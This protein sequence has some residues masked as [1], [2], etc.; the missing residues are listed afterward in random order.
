LTADD[1]QKANNY[2]LKKPLQGL[3]EYAGLIANTIGSKYDELGAV[4]VPSHVYDNL[5]NLLEYV[6]LRQP[7][8]RSRNL[9]FL[10]LRTL[11]SIKSFA[12]ECGSRK[13][14]A[15]M[16]NRKS[17]LKKIQEYQEALNQ[18]LN[19]KDP[20]IMRSECRFNAIVSLFGK[21]N[22]HMIISLNRRRAQS[23]RMIFT[24][25]SDNNVSMGSLIL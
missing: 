13:V 9:H 11:T 20:L 23:L 6:V 12:E 19:P 3:A 25:N 16:M 24:Y 14:F 5:P 10:P 18:S 8:H 21:F 15:G 7:N 22:W 4:S 1:A 2:S 17:D